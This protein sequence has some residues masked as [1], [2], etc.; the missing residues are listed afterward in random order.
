LQDV[1]EDS[2][3]RSRLQTGAA[4]RAARF[5]ADAMVDRYCEIYDEL[6]SGKPREDCGEFGTSE[7]APAERYA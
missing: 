7:F 6:I 5:S 2:Q 4:Q 1:C 3:L